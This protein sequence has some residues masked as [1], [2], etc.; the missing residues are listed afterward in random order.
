[1]NNTRKNFFRKSLMA[2]SLSSALALGVGVA[3]ASASNGVEN[4]SDRSHEAH[5]E[6]ETDHDGIGHGEDCDD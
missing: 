2:V 1:M 6:H 4:S 5:D 3:G